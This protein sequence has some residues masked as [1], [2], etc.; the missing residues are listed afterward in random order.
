MRNYF[1]D[2][3]VLKEKRDRIK[4]KPNE[5]LDSLC[6]NYSKIIDKKFL[7]PEN[8]HRFVAYELKYKN[9]IPFCISYSEDK[10]LAS[11]SSLHNVDSAFPVVFIYSDGIAKFKTE[12]LPKA[13]EFYL[14]RPN[15][16]VLLKLL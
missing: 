8:D 3:F 16:E 6:H 15:K 7:I 14:D 9:K 11:A 13:K 2:A 1:I 5:L 12:S 10:W 4:I